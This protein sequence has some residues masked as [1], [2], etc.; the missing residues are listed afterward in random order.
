MTIKKQLLR[1]SIVLIVVS[2]VA[3]TLAFVVLLNRTSSATNTISQSMSARDEQDMKSEIGALAGAFEVFL[4]E[5]EASID[6]EMHNAALVLQKLDTYTDVS[7]SVLEQVAKETGMNDMYIADMDG[8]FTL[9]TVANATGVSLFDIWDGYRMLVTG[10]ATAL[11]SNLKIMEETGEI[12]KFTAIP[13]YDENG[14]LKGVIESAL[15]AEEIEAALSQMTG[16]YEM[17][18]GLHLFQADGLVLAS[19]EGKNTATSYK[20]G[21]VQSDPN[22]KLALESETPIIVDNGDG[23]I[24]HYSLISRE[25]APAYVMMLEL[26]KNYYVQGTQYVTNALSDLSAV[27]TSSLMVS[28][29]IGYASLVL[30]V[31]LYWRLVKKAVLRPISTLQSVS[32]QIAEGDINVTLDTSRQDEIGKL[33]EDFAQMAGSIQEQAKN[34]QRIAQGDYTSD[35]AIRSAGDMINKAISDM[36][37]SNNKLISE[38]RSAANQVDAGAMQVAQGAQNL[39]AGTGEQTEEVE[40]ISSTLSI[41]VQQTKENVEFAKQALHVNVKSTSM[42]DEAMQTMDKMLEAM[43]AIDHSSQNISKIIKVIEDIAFQTNILALNASVEAARAGESGKGFA[44]V[45]EEVRN[46]ASKST[47]AAKETAALIAGSTAHV[48]EG[49]TLVDQT[50][51]DLIAMKESIQKS[52]ELTQNITTASEKQLSYI[53]DL[54]GSMHHISQVVQ[55]NSATSQEAAAA[56][57]EMSSQSAVLSQMV[58]R[59]KLKK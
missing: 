44:V 51:A 22:I 2:V 58:S 9:S 57:E 47:E 3:Q 14:N 23:K 28:M 41:V 30:V 50:N 42:M 29:A 15:N 5:K 49:S 40:K 6:N 39:A 10:E 45:A 26:D 18:D 13:R 37:I 54:D 8:I 46:L 35:I 34:L 53:T 25:G 20:R 27:F 33:E 36:I 11:P 38:I 52:Y 12:Y 32:K 7:Q 56:A 59:F 31:L 1:L 17:L 48:K 24:Y 43:Q 55:T 21:S 16:K 4:L 19:S